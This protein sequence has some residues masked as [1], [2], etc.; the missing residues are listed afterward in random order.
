[1]TQF[2]H[3]NPE[4]TAIRN[5]YRWTPACQRAFLEEL[6]VTGSVTQACKHIEKSPRSAYDLRF[7]RDGA[8]LALGWDAAILVARVA[9]SGLLMDRVIDGYD[10][11]T[12][13]QDD[14][15]RVRRKYDNKLGQHLLARLDKMA[16][17]QALRN[18]TQAHV[19]MISQ[20]FE[21]YLDLI[22]RGGT[23]AQ[24]A[25]FC[26]ARSADD[27]HIAMDEEYVIGCELDRISAAEDHKIEQIPDMLDEEPEVAAQRLSVWYDDYKNKWKTNFPLADGLCAADCCDEDGDELTEISFFGD[28]DYERRLTSAEEAAHLAALT[29]IRQPW[30]DAAATA[31]DAWFGN[32]INMAA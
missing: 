12:V 17:G 19:Q 7:R 4:L 8:A 27:D 3:T 31:R 10:E 26:T 15:S 5:D 25:L 16:E 29:K 24:A 9:V 28:A 20:D 21:A 14:G 1:M 2:S 23:G 30:I 32:V 22:E 11:V 13:T 18:S 6:A